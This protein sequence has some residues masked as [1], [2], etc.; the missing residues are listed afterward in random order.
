MADYIRRVGVCFQCA[1]WYQIL[2][3]DALD[4][5]RVVILENHHYTIGDEAPCVMRGFGGL[6]WVLALVD[7]R[8]VTTTNLWHQGEIPQR[9]RARF[10]ANS[11]QVREPVR[12]L[13][14]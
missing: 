6:K 4:P 1:R 9:F 3:E 10:P 8:V 13:E 7:G 5:D 11:R 14:L 12:E 2:A